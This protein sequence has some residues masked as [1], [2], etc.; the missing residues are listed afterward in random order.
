MT[1]IKLILRDLT[2]KLYWARDIY[3][4]AMAASLAG[5][6]AFSGSVSV[7]ATSIPTE[8]LLNGGFELGSF[9]HWT[10]TNVNGGWGLQKTISGPTNPGGPAP[11]QD[12]ISGSADAYG[13]MYNIGTSKIEQDFKVPDSMDSAVITWADRLYNAH[14]GWVDGQQNFSVKIVGFPYLFLV[15]LLFS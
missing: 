4:T 15:F 14:T 9:L 6:L 5:G 3:L 11:A 2:D 13:D 12:I 8:A 7:A 10:V 1:G